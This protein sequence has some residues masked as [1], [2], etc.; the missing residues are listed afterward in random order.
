MITQ[1]R[2]GFIS[3]VDV[4]NAISEDFPVFMLVDEDTG[5]AFRLGFTTEAL[6]ELVGLGRDWAGLGT[7]GLEHDPS[8]LDDEGMDEDEDGDDGLTKAGSR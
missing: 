8:D 4:D 6:F 5:F 1:I 7:D 2:E 3:R